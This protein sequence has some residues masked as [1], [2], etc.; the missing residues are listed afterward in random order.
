MTDEEFH[1]SELLENGIITLE[2]LE[3][4]MDMGDNTGSSFTITDEEPTPEGFDEF[5]DDYDAKKIATKDFADY[6]DEDFDW[7]NWFKSQ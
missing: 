6:E 5:F 2:E 7:E 1:L 4:M 3:V